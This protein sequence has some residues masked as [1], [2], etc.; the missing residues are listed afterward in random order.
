MAQRT[1]FLWSVVA[2]VYIPLGAVALLGHQVH[3]EASQGYSTMSCPVSILK[4]VAGTDYRKVFHLCY[5]QSYHLAPPLSH[6][7]KLDGN[8]PGGMIHIP[9]QKLA[10]SLRS[11][12][13]PP[14]WPHWVSDTG[15]TVRLFKIVH[16][17]RW[18]SVDR[19]NHYLS[20][21]SF[22]DFMGA[23]FWGKFQLPL[24]ARA[25]PLRTPSIRLT[26]YF[27]L[28]LFLPLTTYLVTSTIR[29]IAFNHLTWTDT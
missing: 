1:T 13:F 21:G 25:T 7:K 17:N 4:Q 11:E 16:Q 8:T 6:K 3:A 2:Q 19:D 5:W 23:I 20:N 26:L 12:A 29:R 14:K 27:N 10:A 9:C 18:L 15:W 28:R 22:Y 24:G